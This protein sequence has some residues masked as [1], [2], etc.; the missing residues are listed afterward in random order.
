[1]STQD[2]KSHAS[3]E[4]TTSRNA[5]CK[6]LSKQTKLERHLY[7]LR[8]PHAVPNGKCR[9]EPLAA[10]S[11]VFNSHG[12]DKMWLRTSTL[13]TNGDGIIH[14]LRMTHTLCTC[15]NNIPYIYI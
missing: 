13:G 15:T 1:M 7:S 8:G 5:R 2:E 12:G 10:H 14:A 6:T 9:S 3:P 4:T 11:S